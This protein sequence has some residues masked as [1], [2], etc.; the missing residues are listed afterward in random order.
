MQIKQCREESE[1]AKAQD[2]TKHL[3]T[4]CPSDQ[5]K[6]QRSRVQVYGNGRGVFVRETRWSVTTIGLQDKKTQDNKEK[7]H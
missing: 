3:K 2:A 4:K 1:N 5:L 7:E 6:I